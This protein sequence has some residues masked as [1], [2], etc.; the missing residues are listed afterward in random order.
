[1]AL[2]YPSIDR[3]RVPAEHRLL[4]LDRR[5]FPFAIVALVVWALWALVLP[6]IDQAVPWSDPIRPGDV[7]QVTGTVTMTPAVGWALQ[8]GLR[9]TDRTAAGDPPAVTLADD[10]VLLQITH[11]PWAGDAAQL[12]QQIDRITTT[13]AGGSSLQIA[14]GAR[15]ITARSGEAGVLETFSSPRAEGVLGAF[16]FDGTGVE[17][18][19]VGPPQRL[20]AHSDDIIAMISSLTSTA[21]R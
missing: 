5:T 11:G 6:W 2:A 16:V 15:T 7:V 12:L 4:G 19:A 20:A 10:G 18:Q 1:M 9:T 3:G 8:S 21:V 14:G 17:I 13:V